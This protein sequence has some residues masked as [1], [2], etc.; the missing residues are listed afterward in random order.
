MPFAILGFGSSPQRELM[1]A[2]GEWKND[3]LAELRSERRVRLLSRVVGAHPG[4]LER[5]SDPAPRT[6]NRPF[7]D[8]RFP[9]KRI[10]EGIQ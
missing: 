10:I 7:G 3:V 2:G 9:G 4:I 8:G 6:Y 1:E 5:R